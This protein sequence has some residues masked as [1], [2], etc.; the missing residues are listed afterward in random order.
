VFAV[1][2]TGPPGAGKTAALTALSDAL[3]EDEIEH[4][5]VD[6]DEVAWAFPF[7][8]DAE[9]C[10]L[11]RASCDA[12]RRAGHDLLLVAEVLESP[13]HLDDILRSVGADGHLLVRL[14]ARL[15]TMRERIIT[16]E[17]EGWFGLEYLLGELERLVTTLP[18]FADAEVVLDSEQLAAREIAARIRLACPGRLGG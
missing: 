4:A 14:E 15:A 8:D 13:G 12:H 6:I 11:L 3:V 2:V 9:R 5:A 17:P 10:E 16:R 1:V 7:P 18:T